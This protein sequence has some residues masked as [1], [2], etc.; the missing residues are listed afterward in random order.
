MD[1]R[2]GVPEFDVGLL[3]PGPEKRA[4]SCG[5]RQVEDTRAIEVECTTKY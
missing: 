3:G 2:G 1:M 4:W 5:P